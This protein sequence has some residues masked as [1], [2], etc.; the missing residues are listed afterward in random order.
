MTPFDD[1]I[2][3]ERLFD[4]LDR[5]ESKIDEKADRIDGKIDDLCDRTTKLET[6]YDIHTDNEKAK[7]ERKEKIFYGVL[8]VFGL[9]ISLVELIRS[10]IIG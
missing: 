6:K 4:K 9:V 10:G 2:I 7:S 8:G 1:N 5:L 3:M